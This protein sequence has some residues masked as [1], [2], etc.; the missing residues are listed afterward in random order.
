MVNSSVR[1]NS[2]SM[3]RKD[4]ARQQANFPHLIST[5]Q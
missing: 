4:N 5:E 2:G 3:T 1:V